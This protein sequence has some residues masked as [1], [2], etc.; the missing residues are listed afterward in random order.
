MANWARA[1]MEHKKLMNMLTQCPMHVIFCLRAREKT[2]PMKDAQ[3]KTIMVDLGMQAIQEKNFMY[4][5]TVSMMLTDAEPGRP[6][7]TKCPKPLLELFTGKQALITKAVGEKLSAWAKGGAPVDMEFRK[8]K[9]DCSTA[10]MEGG[11]AL[12]SFWETLSN[13]DKKSLKTYMTE[14]KATAED[15]DRVEEPETELP[16][17]FKKEG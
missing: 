4:E 9:L 15:V 11:A 5:M 16:N 2:K 1:K 6:K 13:E 8:L 14:F 7:I 12:K 3:G 10:A 17:L